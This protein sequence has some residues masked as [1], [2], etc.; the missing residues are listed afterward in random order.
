MADK[1][2]TFIVEYTYGPDGPEQKHTHLTVDAIDL[3]HAAIA[4]EIAITETNSWISCIHEKDIS[5]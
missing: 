5:M 2:H 1:L 3:K 4:A